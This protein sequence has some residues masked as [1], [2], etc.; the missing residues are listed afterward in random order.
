MEKKWFKVELT[1]RRMLGRKFAWAETS[2]NSNTHERK[3]T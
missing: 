3:N 1:A 2:I